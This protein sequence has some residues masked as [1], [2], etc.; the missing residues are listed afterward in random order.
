[1]FSD[2]PQTRILHQSRNRFN[3][4]IRINLSIVNLQTGNGAL[5][6]ARSFYIEIKWFVYIACPYD[7]VLRE[8][9]IFD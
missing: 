6:A 8:G 7:D 4:V 3:F 2:F 1:M 9:R 5:S